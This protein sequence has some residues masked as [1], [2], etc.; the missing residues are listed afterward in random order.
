MLF[1]LLEDAE[2]LDRD[3]P[4]DLFC[5]HFIFIPRINLTLNTFRDSYSH[6][7][8]QTAQNRNPYQLWISGMLQNSGDSA[9]VQGV[10]EAT[11]SVSTCTFVIVFIINVTF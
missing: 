6:H 9:A 8:L 5:L 10:E 4:V 7:P 2:L 1:W 11:V 3:N